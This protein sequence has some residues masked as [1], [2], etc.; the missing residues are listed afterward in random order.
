MSEVGGLQSAARVVQAIEV[1]ARRGEMK[2]SE[3]AADLG[4]HKSNALRLL[5][6][7]RTLGWVAVDAE[8]NNYKVGPALVGIGQAAAGAMDIDELLHTAGIVRDIT[9]ESVH[10]AVPNGHHM[11][12]VARIDSHHALRVSCRIGSQDA[13]YNSGLGKA[14]LASLPGDEVD[15]LLRTVSFE[16]CTPTTLTTPEAL[17]EDLRIT[18]ERGYAVDLG[19]A[20]EGVQC[21]GVAVTVGSQAHT[22]AISVTGP[23]ERWTLELIEEKAPFVLEV[24]R[25]YLSRASSGATRP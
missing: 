9:G 24:L 16:R 6:T 23:A 12:I 20:R 5:E 18:R 10:I 3:V 8:R 15:T 2:L 25:P 13:L 14:Y 17:R 11:L 22:V 21:M 19:E 1:M 7:L 4:I